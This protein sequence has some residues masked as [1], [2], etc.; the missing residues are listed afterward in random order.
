MKKNACQFIAFMNKNFFE[1]MSENS[2]FTFLKLYKNDSEDPLWHLEM[3]EIYYS[4]FL[5][6]N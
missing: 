6:M 1:C 4:V 5:H 3:K 2:E